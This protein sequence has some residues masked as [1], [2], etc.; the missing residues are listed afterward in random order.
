MLVSSIDFIGS[1]YVYQHFLNLL[2]LCNVYLAGGTLGLFT[3]AS[4][5]SIFEFVYWLYRVSNM[6]YNRII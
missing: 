1:K 3:G 2:A 4:L 5:I 6:T